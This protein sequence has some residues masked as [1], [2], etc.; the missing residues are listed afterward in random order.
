M[1]ALNHEVV[2]NASGRR[3]GFGDLGA[4]AAKEPVPTV[5]GL[6]LKDPEDFRYLGK[7]QISMVDLRDITALRVTALTSAG[8][9]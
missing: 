5:E 2:H 1:K 7:G 6:R 4:D 9:A 8:P 3:L